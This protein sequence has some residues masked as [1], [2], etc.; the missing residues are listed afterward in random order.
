MKKVRE[1]KSWIE[2]YEQVTSAVGDLQVL[3]DFAKEGE[4][5]E[6]EVDAQYQETIRVLEDIEMRNMLRREEDHFG[7]IMKINSG[8][9]RYGKYGLGQYAVPGCTSAGRIKRLQGKTR[10]LPGR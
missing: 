7:A 3:F 8:S 1:L 4:A 2:G 10:G 6:E 9:R 5:T